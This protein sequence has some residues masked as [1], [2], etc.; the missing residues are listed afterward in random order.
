MVD[1]EGMWPEDENEGEDFS[2]NSNPWSLSKIFSGIFDRLRS[3]IDFKNQ[4]QQADLEK[5]MDEE[6]SQ[7]MGFRLN[8][9]AGEEIGRGIVDFMATTT[10]VYTIGISGD[11][12]GSSSGRAALHFA[13]GETYLSLGGSPSPSYSVVPWRVTPYFNISFVRNYTTKNYE[14]GFWDMSFGFI[15]GYGYAQGVKTPQ[16]KACYLSFSPNLYIS[17]GYEHYWR[18]K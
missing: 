14:D 9:P 4:N 17:F 11:F 7:D 16:C 12:H 10:P 8:L 15:V 2:G 5:E 13:P 3:L 18:M 6:I 1:P